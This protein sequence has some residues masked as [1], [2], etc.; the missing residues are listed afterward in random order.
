MTT[1]YLWP[2]FYTHETKQEYKLPDGRVVL[3]L[4]NSLAPT[5]EDCEV[6]GQVHFRAMLLAVDIEYRKPHPLFGEPPP[7]TMGWDYINN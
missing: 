1:E 6:V 5:E 3:G 2:E 7:K 4:F